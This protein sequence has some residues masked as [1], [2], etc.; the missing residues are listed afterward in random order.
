MN[1]QTDA[2][3]EAVAEGVAV[4]GLLDDA[5]AGRVHVPAGHTGLAARDACELRIQHGV[6]DETHFIGHMIDRDRARH[7]RAVAVIDA[8]EVHRDEIACLDGL[9][10]GHAVRFGAVRTRNNDRVKRH[11]FRAV[12]QHE[13][14]QAGG[15]LL[16]GHADPDV[17][18]HLL[19]R[20]LGDTLRRDDLFDLG[21]LLHHAQAF[22]AVLEPDRRRVE[23]GGPRHE[24]RVGQRFVLERDLFRTVLLDESVDEGGIALS[25]LDLAHL[26]IRDGRARRLGIAEVCEENGLLRGEVDRACGGVEAGRVAAADLARQ[27]HRVIRL[28]CE[29]SS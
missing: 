4:T 24:L 29:K 19:E 2:V 14:G 18:Q 9:F 6:V 20:L 10:G 21:V 25:G 11:V 12:V 28:F 27:H 23:R 22:H 5:A 8:A 16:F 13:V 26:E 17:V 1:L 15:D 7:V 3:T